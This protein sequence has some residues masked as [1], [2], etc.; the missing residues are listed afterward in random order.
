MNVCAVHF[1]L[2]RLSAFGMDDPQNQFLA[3]LYGIAMGTRYVFVHP[4]RIR[5]LAKRNCSHQEPMMRSTPVEFSIEHPSVAWDYVANND[6]IKQYWLE[7]AQRAKNFES[8]YTLGMRG[9]GDCAAIFLLF[10]FLHL[11]NNSL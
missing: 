11:L 3:D 1:E 8:V 4:S 10:Y 7:G 5:T 9:F 2:Y 6:T